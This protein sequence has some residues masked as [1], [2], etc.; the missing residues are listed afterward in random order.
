MALRSL[1]FLLP[2][3]VATYAATFQELNAAFYEKKSKEEGV[4]MLD[5]GILIK[6]LEEGRGKE[7]PEEYSPCLI[8]FEGKYINEK[9]R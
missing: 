1:V 2:L 4:K 3:L 5:N 8:H 9:T 7:H 6:V